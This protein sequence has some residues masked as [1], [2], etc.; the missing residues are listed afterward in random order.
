[1]KRILFL[2]VLA[3]LLAA[4]AWA[5]FS[6]YPA[7]AV[8]GTNV[9]LF[10]TEDNVDPPNKPIHFQ[11]SVDGGN[12]WMTTLVWTD[13]TGISDS[14][15]ISASGT[16]V[17]LTWVNNSA[18]NNEIYFQASL[19]GGINWQPRVRLSTTSGASLHPAIASSGSYVYVAWS[20]NTTG[21]AAIYFR[22]SA[23]KGA[24]WG[25]TQY[26]SNPYASIN[27]TDAYDPALA[28]SGAKVYVAWYDSGSPHHDILFRKSATYGQTW[29]PAKNLSANA[30][31]SSE[32][33]LA[34]VSG[35]VY[36]VWQDATSGNYEI[37]L[38]RSLDG[39]ATWKAAQ[40]LSNNAGASQ[41][42]KVVSAGAYVYVAWDDDTYGYTEIHFRRSTDSG[43]TWKP[44]VQMTTSLS[45]IFP[46]LALMSSNIYLLYWAENTP[47]AWY[48]FFQKSTDWGVTWTSPKFQIY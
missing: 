1:M 46:A 14:P 37:L 11:R 39:G 45:C 43:L 4:P 24:H 21:R 19:D 13:L 35:K 27:W 12:T 9:Y 5:S 29:S 18:G 36:A 15:A 31:D 33:A 3:L 10:W 47:S 28:A 41:N 40:N 7:M 25:T 16:S 30:G 38:R 32:P 34:V 6:I 42:P 2:G 17:Y 8:Q 22:K 23:D 44:S 48:G 20:D 26:L